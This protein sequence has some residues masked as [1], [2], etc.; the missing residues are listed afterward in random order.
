MS[1]RIARAAASQKAHPT[2]TEVLK[3]ADTVEFPALYLAARQH[4][5]ECHRVDECKDIADKMAALAVYVKQVHDDKLENLVRR[6]KG[7][8]VLRMGQILKSIKASPGARTDKPD[9]A[10]GTRL[11]TRTQAAKDAGISKRQAD[12]AKRV[13][14]LHEQD[15]DRAEVML[16][17]GASVTKMAEAGTKKRQEPPE[18]L[19]GRD[20]SVFNQVLNWVG[21]W[22][23]AAERDELMQFNP[24]LVGDLTMMERDRLLRAVRRV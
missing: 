12:D 11:Q 22:E 1:E 5:S 10:G 20:P 9:T 14:T 19:E 16:E 13:A 8:A 17:S 7:R 3:L 15:P 6:I 18:Y 4:L 2:T 21:T 23:H 24:K